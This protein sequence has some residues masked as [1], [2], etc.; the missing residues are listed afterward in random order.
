MMK[1]LVVL[2][3]LALAMTA[4][5]A[6][7]QRSSRRSSGGPIELGIDGGITF[8]LDDPHFTLVSLPTQVFRV[9]Y[10]LNDRFEIEP[11]LSLNSVSGGGARVTLYT[12]GAGLLYQPNG[13]RVGKGL[14]FRPFVGLNGVSVSDGGGSDSSGEVG[15]GV[16]LKLPF[17]D[18]R[19][20]T[21]LEANY[22]HSDGTNLIGLLFG[23]SWFTR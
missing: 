3:A 22:A 13:D 19:L 14:Y 20:A 10:F 4:S 17:D 5:T 6:D 11:R 2:G 21:R 7:G 15:I 1:R 12:L 18:R 8:G 16:G 23:L 9:G